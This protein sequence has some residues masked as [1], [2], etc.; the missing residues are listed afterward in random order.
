[1]ILPAQIYGMLLILRAPRCLKQ[2]DM[3]NIYNLIRNV[4]LKEYFNFV[5]N[6]W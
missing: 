6:P 5:T 4:K 2:K 3:S 1:M